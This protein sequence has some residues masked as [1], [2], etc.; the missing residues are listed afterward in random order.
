[1]K[2][3]FLTF[4]VTIFLLSFV[5]AGSCTPD[6]GFSSCYDSSKTYKTAHAVV[7]VQGTDVQGILKGGYY[8]GEAYVNIKHTGDKFYVVKDATSWDDVFAKLSCG[9][10]GC[11]GQEVADGKYILATPGQQPISCPAFA[12]WDYDEASNGDWAWTSQGWG[13]IGKAC[14]V[15]NIK[16]VQ[17]YDNADCS[18]NTYCDKSGTWKEWSC[19][20]AECF[21]DQT[22]CRGSNQFVC[23][24]Y[25]WK[26]NGLKVNQCGVQCLQ[27]SDCG[28]DGPTDP[29]CTEAGNIA[30]KSL[31]YTC[32]TL[33]TCSNN[34]SVALKKEC[35]FGCM[36]GQCL[37]DTL[38]EPQATTNYLW[39]L[40]PI[41]MIAAVFGLVIAIIRK[42]KK[43]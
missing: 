6:F 40:I 4:T 33:N 11:T 43:R 31:T 37:S 9:K 16:S 23:D 21:P 13:W 42:R 18:G 17:C 26:D 8:V 25:R 7:Q 22:E 28:T 14:S 1:M 5:L 41:V 3:I 35:P 32:S 20:A 39:Y 34:E 29:Y 27:A 2:H 10:N 12:A 15:A 38:S 36:N 19:K 30:Q 24:N